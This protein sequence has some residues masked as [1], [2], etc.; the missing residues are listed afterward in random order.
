MRRTAV[1]LAILV[2]VSGLSRPAAGQ[3]SGV[4]TEYLM[5]YFAPLERYPIDGS[6]VIVN[7][8]PGGWVKGP[9]ITGKIIAP[10]GDWVTVTPSGVSRLDV[11]L[12]IETDDGAHIYMTYNGIFVTSK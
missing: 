2:A 8:R 6:R 12:L 10:G 3:T 4:S 7:V 5:T 1:V 11:R 9:R